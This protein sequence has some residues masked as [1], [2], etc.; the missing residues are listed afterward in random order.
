MTEV[1]SN[2]VKSQ[3]TLVAAL[4]NPTLYPHPVDRVEQ[5]ETH[6]SYILLAGDYAYKIKKPLNLGF[7]DFT[8]LEHRRYFCHEELRLNRRLA[9]ALYLDCIP[10]CGSTENP[11]LGG[12]EGNALEYAVKMRRFPQHALLNHR[13]AEGA[14]ESHHIDDLARQV[15][16]FHGA[17]ERAS[18]ATP[19]GSAEYTRQPALENFRVLRGL[20]RDNRDREQAAALERWTVCRYEKLR[21][22]LEARKRDGFVRECHGDLHLGNIILQGSEI[23]IFDCIE[24]SDA[25]RWIDVVNDLAFLYMDLF[26]CAAPELGHRLL[27]GYL[28][29]SGDYA[30]LCLLPYYQVY[31]A[32]VRAK[33]AAIRLGQANLDEAQRQTTAAECRAYLKLGLEFTRPQRP[34]L[35]LTHGLSGSGKSHLSNQLVERLGAVR[36]RSDVERKR[37]FGLAPLASSD[38]PPDQGI[39]SATAT[40]RTY[41]RLLDMARGILAA[42]YPVVV[43]ATFLDPSWRQRF[44]D[45]ARRHHVPFVL[46]ACAADPEVLR[47][48]VSQRHARGNDAAEADLAILERQ[49]K[50]YTPPTPEEQALDTAGGDDNALVEAILARI[51]E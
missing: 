24:F 8:T 13:L 36:I 43:D 32:M 7:L 47:A 49:L 23:T 44:R 4:H 45:F 22:V 26:H 5:L 10:I 40:E 16:T 18:P 34:F 1:C 17:I 21:S 48:R 37:L 50:G 19:L 31:R 12:Q 33:I 41:A 30:G 2:T 38:S 15:A 39:Y 42:N 46:L 28:E 29:F 9:P 14:L 11:V 27:S 51:E 6:I 25:L 35:V 3:A 20:L